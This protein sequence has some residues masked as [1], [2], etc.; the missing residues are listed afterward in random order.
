MK[1]ILL[2]TSI[3]ITN[4]SSFLAAGSLANS[5]QDGLPIQ[6]P[7]PIKT[8]E[9]QCILSYTCETNKK[10]I[11]NPSDPDKPKIFYFGVISYRLQNDIAYIINTGNIARAKEI[12]IQNETQKTVDT[13]DLAQAWCTNKKEQIHNFFSICK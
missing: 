1:N 2:L 4:Y 9:R 3:F 7:A 13:A 11:Y 8:T 5:V 12:S 10:S 6:I